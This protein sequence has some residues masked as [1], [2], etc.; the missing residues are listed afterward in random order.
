[1]SKEKDILNKINEMTKRMRKNI[2]DMSLSAGSESSHF[3]GGL[4]IVEITATLFGSIMSYDP[5]NPEWE[6]RDRFI[7]SKGHGCLGYYTALH[8][9]GLISKDD[10][11]KFE[12][13]NSYLLGHP[14]MNRKKGIEFSNGSLGMGLSIGIGVALAAKKRKKNY[15]VY[16]LIGDGECNEGSVWEA[17]MAA[18]NFK[19]NNI[20]S[21]VDRN[22]LQQTGTNKEI[23][24]VGDIAEKWR[25]FAW[26]VIEL[27][28]HNIKELYDAFSNERNSTKPLAIIANTI[29]GKGFSFSENNNDWH[30]KIMSKSQYELAI[31]ELEKK[32]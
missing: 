29:K 17:A 32:L 22:N 4:S 8:E 27:D 24:S 21:I 5:K 6:D 1:M 15:K 20:I 12:K 28:G 30:H 16:V 19:L 18:P 31:K 14:V 7:L 2:L 13:T 3:G 11:M 25:S 9:I 26:D 23:M 10:L